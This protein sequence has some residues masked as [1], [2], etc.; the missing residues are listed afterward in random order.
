MKPCYFKLWDDMRAGIF[1]GTGHVDS[2]VW[3]F[4]LSATG[5][6]FIWDGT[7]PEIESSL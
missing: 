2:C 7:F 6:L 5:W 4:V 1:D 3:G